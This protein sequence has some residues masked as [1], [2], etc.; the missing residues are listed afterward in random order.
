[1]DLNIIVKQNS[2]NV[3]DDKNTLRE[4]INAAVT[5]GYSTIALNT[6]IDFK[7]IKK[8]TEIPK[9]SH[10]IE[11]KKDDSPIKVLSRLTALVSTEI[12]CHYLMQ[13]DTYKIYDILSIQPENEKMFK[14]ILNNMNIDII[15][16]NL[17][18]LP[19]LIKRN[20]VKQAINK[21]MCFEIEYSQLLRNRLCR[22]WT[23]TKGRNLIS[24]NCKKN[25]IISSG[26]Q[27]YMDIRQPEEVA[28]LGL[29]FGLNLN[30]GRDAVFKNA[31]MI[32]DHAYIR[33]KPGRD[34]V[35]VEDADQIDESEKWLI[36]ACNFPKRIEL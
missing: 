17:E 30:E 2:N 6:I 33:R 13:S 5:W 12:H 29:L 9:P 8:A 16:L 36:E 35:S 10:L 31:Q 1:M 21:G 14:Y 20:H 22:I 28:H 19:F 25:I 26:A 11:V 34:I 24:N 3:D 7:T 15:S 4:I 32:I 27:N 18:N 23:I